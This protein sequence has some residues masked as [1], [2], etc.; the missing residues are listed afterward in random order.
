LEAAFNDHGIHTH[1]VYMGPWDKQ[2][3]WTSMVLA[4]LGANPRDFDSS[5]LSLSKR[6]KAHARRW[7]FYLNFLPETWARYLVLVRPYLLRRQVVLLDRHVFDLEAG[8]FN[9]PMKNLVWVRRVLVRLSP[10]PHLSILLDNDAETIW[11]RKKEFP[12]ALIQSSLAF[13][14][15]AARRYGMLII[16][17]EPSPERLAAELIATHWRDFV[18]WRREGLFR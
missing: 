8:Y 15:Q 9:E 3:L 17:T 11:K 4:R 7:L 5:G 13:Y 16:R 10:R 12:L 1:C 2:F 18:R 6:L 14:H